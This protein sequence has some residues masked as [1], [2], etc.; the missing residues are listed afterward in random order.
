MFGDGTGPLRPVASQLDGHDPH[1]AVGVAPPVAG[2]VPLTVEA[3]G[4]ADLIVDRLGEA[5]ALWRRRVCP[6]SASC[7]A[8]PV[9]RAGR[10]PYLF[11]RSRSVPPPASEPASP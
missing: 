4:A 1:D 6:A 2:G 9:G 3:A 11:P 10:S 5:R 8:G 7:S